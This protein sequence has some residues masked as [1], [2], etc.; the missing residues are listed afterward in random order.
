MH[1]CVLKKKGAKQFYRNHATRSIPRK[2]VPF[3]V[4]GIEVSFAFPLPPF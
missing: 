4:L 2:T 3:S 1:I